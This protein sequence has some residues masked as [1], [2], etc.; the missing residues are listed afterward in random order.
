MVD[1]ADPD[2]RGRVA[3]RRGQLTSSQVEARQNRRIDLTGVPEGDRVRPY[4]PARK[5]KVTKHR[6]DRRGP[7][8]PV[9]P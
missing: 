9:P 7:P 3:L 8:G 2:D 5:R 1:A 4:R 6:P